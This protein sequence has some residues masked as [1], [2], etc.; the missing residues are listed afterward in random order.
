[1]DRAMKEEGGGALGWAEDEDYRTYRDVAEDVWSLDRWQIL[2]RI[3]FGVV[4]LNSLWLVIRMAKAVLN[5]LFDSYLDLSIPYIF[6]SLFFPAAL[7]VWSTCYKDLRDF[8]IKKFHLWVAIINA[9]LTV[10]A[11]VVV[12]GVGKLVTV[13]ATNVGQPSE[14]FD[15]ADAAKTVML[16]VA[17]ISVAAFVF[18]VV[19]IDDLISGTKIS[20]SLLEYQY[21]RTRDL[22]KNKEFKYDMYAVKRK[23]TGEDVQVFEQDRFTGTCA[24]GATGTGK[25][26]SAI[27][28]AILH[29]TEVMRHNLDYQKVE[30]AKLLKN[31]QARLNCNFKDEDF[32]ISYIDP[33]YTGDEAKDKKLKKQFKFLNEVSSV[34]GIIAMAPDEG[35]ADDICAMFEAQHLPYKRVDTTLDSHGRPKP[36]T[37]GFNPLYISPF[38]TG[39]DHVQDVVNKAAI[40]ANV[41]ACLNSMG[42]TVDAYFAGVNSTQTNNLC[43]LVMLT[44]PQLMKD[45]AEKEKALHKDWDVSVT[46]KQPNLRVFQSY[47]NDYELL[48]EPLC[49]LVEM[50]GNHGKP[51]DLRRNDPVNG[52]DPNK[53]REAVHAALSGKKDIDC[54]IWQDVYTYVLN[55]MLNPKEGVAT[56]DRARGLRDQVNRF[57]NNPRVNRC[58]LSDDSIDLDECLLNA[59]SVVYN[60]SF[61][62]G[63]DNSTAFGLFFLLS[64]CQA[65]LRRKVGTFLRPIFFYV[66]EFTQILHAETQTMFTLFRKY[67]VAN[68]IAF[69]GLEN[70]N[71]TNET[72]YLR[73]IV[74]ENCRTRIFFGT[75]VP[76]SMRYVEMLFGEVITEEIRKGTSETAMSM[77]N[78][79]LTT[80]T[81]VTEKRAPRIYA[82]DVISMSFQDVIMST[83]RNGNPVEAFQGRV[84]F[85]RKADK[86]GLRRPVGNWELYYSDSN[87]EPYTGIKSGE[88]FGERV[89]GDGV[90]AP[91]PDASTNVYVNDGGQR[92]DF[93]G[94]RQQAENMMN[95]NAWSGRTDSMRF[96]K[97]NEPMFGSVSY[98]SPVPQQINAP[99]QTPE[100]AQ[101]T[102]PQIQVQRQEPAEVTTPAETPAPVQTPNPE[103]PSENGGRKVELGDRD[104]GK[105]GEYVMTPEEIAQYE[106]KKMRPNQAGRRNATAEELEEV[107]RKAQEKMASAEKNPENAMSSLFD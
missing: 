62:L 51:Y 75:L 71:R 99:V 22:R 64:F 56:F 44:Y 94:M 15:E 37:I 104:T 61:D 19:K 79:S 42:G 103:Q 100:Q 82:S 59:R 21:N 1:M 69:Q 54:G 84:D 27:E 83:V 68:Y 52:I 14:M 97:A 49:K 12:R 4:M 26:S 86:K 17:F 101:T 107:R 96:V 24:V 65:V 13:F 20:R 41:M 80:T 10:E 40:V 81:S 11:A 63:R 30:V 39:P 18:A 31:G 6:V 34:A 7:W 73:D 33:V 3:L 28:P 53:G 47:I 76:D 2:C 16:L 66:D 35:M 74:I 77:E 98:V 32:S 43:K 55:E 45:K 8:N 93:N 89:A 58:L 87:G 60:Y 106:S 23:D 70:F 92:S 102:Q 50:Y 105:N 85:M 29:D 5:L 95:Q 38:V 67:R 72:K 88:A 46:C 48:A 36:N 78:P 90:S 91:A 9:L 25:T 57:L